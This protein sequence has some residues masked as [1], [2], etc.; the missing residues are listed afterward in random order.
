MKR[1]KNQ[2]Q[3]EKNK[4]KDPKAFIENNSKYSKKNKR[5]KRGVFNEASPFYKEQELKF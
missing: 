1:S 4:K 5:Q 3:K 2:Q